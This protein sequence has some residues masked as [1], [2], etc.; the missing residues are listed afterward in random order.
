M[1]ALGRYFGYFLS[2]ISIC[3]L[4]FYDLMHNDYITDLELGLA[5]CASLTCSFLLIWCLE[6]NDDLRE[7]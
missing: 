2:L 4:L 3:C 7:Y 5:A 1:K 6:I